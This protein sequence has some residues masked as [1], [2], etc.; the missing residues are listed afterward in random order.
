MWNPSRRTLIQA[1]LGAG[2]LT[3]GPRFVGPAFA[4]NAPGRAGYDY[5]PLQPVNADGLR[6]PRGFSSRIVAVADQ[7]VG[8]SGY[9]WHR[10]PD[11][12]ACYATPDGGWI[13]VSNAERSAPNGGVGAIRFAAGGAIVD[14]Y[15]ICSGTARNCAGGPTPWGTWITCEEVERGRAIECDPFGV[16]PQRTLD[17]LGWFYREAVA[18][19]PVHGHVYHT[20]DRSD[21]KLYRTRH[22]NFPDL[23]TGILEAAVVGPGSPADVRTLT[24]VPVPNPN[25][26]ASQPTT[27]AQVPQATSFARGEGMWY[28][29]GRVYFATTSDNRVWMID[30][31]AQTITTVYD[32]AATSP[33]GIASGVDNICVSASGEIL[34]AEDG[35]NMEIVLLAPEGRLQPLVEIVHS[36][37]EVAGPAFSPDGTRL[38]FSSQRGPSA[39]GGANGVT[40]EVTGPFR[41]VEQLLADGFET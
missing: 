1:M 20:E 38:Y 30:C 26:S 17:A 3:I 39:N 4:A 12:G 36:G 25:P 33:P 34:I 7:V 41:S 40:F 13:Y 10:A 19:D 29:D 8:S 18:V 15:P 21:G 23:S 6:L 5:G 9:S 22:A 11:G 27:R 31:A 28:H 24:W 2:V 32:R 14:A 35:G 16:Q 37:S